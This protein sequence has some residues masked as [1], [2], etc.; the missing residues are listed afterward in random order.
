[1]AGG[2]TD[3]P[4][5]RGDERLHNLTTMPWIGVTDTNRDPLE[6]S[7][8][9]LFERA[10]DLATFEMESPL[11]DVSVMRM[12]L[13]IIYRALGGP[14]DYH[15]WRELTWAH[16]ARRS[17]AYLGDHEDEF[18][19]IHPTRPF[20]QTLGME[21]Q[22]ASPMSKFTPLWRTLDGGRVLHPVTNDG[23]DDAPDA[24]AAARWIVAIQ[25]WDTG[26]LKGLPVGHP[27]GGG[28]NRISRPASWSAWGGVLHIEKGRIA[29]TLL[30]NL[31]PIG[32][33]GE[34]PMA[35]SGDADLPAWELPTPDLRTLSVKETAVP[36][37]VI[38]TYTHRNR[39]ILLVWD[40]ER[41]RVASVTIAHGRS[42]AS[43][44][45]SP[46]SKETTSLRPDPMTL[47]REKGKGSLPVGAGLWRGLPSMIP[48]VP[49]AVCVPI[50]DW[51]AKTLEPGEL[52]EFAY[53]TH[54]YGPKMGI[55]GETISDHLAVPTDILRDPALGSEVLSAYRVGS[56]LLGEVSR[57]FLDQVDCLEGC[58]ATKPK[59]KP[60][61]GEENLHRVPVR[62]AT[63]LRYTER[64]VAEVGSVFATW[65]L[66]AP[67]RDPVTARDAFLSEL[68][69]VM[70]RLTDERLRVTRPEAFLW[71]TSG[72][73]VGLWRARIIAKTASSAEI[74]AGR[75]LP[76]RL[77]HCAADSSH[78]QDARP[79]TGG[80]T[81]PAQEDPS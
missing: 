3:V 75:G 72:A 63:S 8:V 1:M 20:L 64:F 74:E 30:A 39:S 66:S 58:H 52:G 45:K 71:G 15:E 36:T 26:G 68:R 16:V 57:F 10:E 6:V 19:L 49:D 31:M 54:A 25:A 78:T 43:P 7:L 32:E 34:R 47:P 40:E 60:A 5:E 27:D 55:F 48:N 17:I 62:T 70:L 28:G 56:D 76:A 24:A 33:E 79:S 29:D 21:G 42:F 12:V 41:A 81:R 13:A 18:W 69:A 11:Q 59:G 35:F 38:D 22:Q 80:A 67:G 9:Q 44:A 46:D 61:K 50:A 65:V 23:T 77:A 73:V 14:R 2:T 51:A 37:G 53:V 4:R